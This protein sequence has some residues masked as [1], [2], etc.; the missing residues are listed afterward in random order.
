MPRY[1]F[2]LRNSLD[3]E[4]REGV[5]L[6]DEAA[7]RAYAVES[8]RDLAAADVRQGWLDLDHAIEVA[9]GARTLFRI[10]YGE[11]VDLRGDR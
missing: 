5:E 9:D 11:A 3:A 7:A 8:A 6:A 2:H 4:D 10:P 1:F